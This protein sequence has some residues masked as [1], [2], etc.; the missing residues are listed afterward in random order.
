MANSV[1]LLV[2]VALPTDVKRRQNLRRTSASRP[3]HTSR[4]TVSQ[5]SPNPS[6]PSSPPVSLPAPSPSARHIRRMTPHVCVSRAVK[7]EGGESPKVET[8]S[9]LC[10]NCEG[11]GAISC[12]Q[13][14]GTGVNKE[15]FFAGRFKAGQICWLCRG[16]RQMLCGDCNGAGFLG[17]FLSTQEE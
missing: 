14:E 12:N 9:I 7:N 6:P 10:Q 3:Q 4:T 1:A 5:A 11:N 17:G 13:C 8:K 2:A 15:D 16:K